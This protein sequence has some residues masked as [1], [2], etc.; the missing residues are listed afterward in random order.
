MTEII[1]IMMLGYSPSNP[2]NPPLQIFEYEQPSMEVCEEQRMKVND[3]NLNST[4]DFQAIC[5]TRAKNESNIL[6]H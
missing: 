2:A 5:V 6:R 1:L 3:A 4:F